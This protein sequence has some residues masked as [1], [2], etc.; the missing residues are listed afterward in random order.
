MNE[1]RDKIDIGQYRHFHVKLRWQ[2][3][4]DLDLSAFMLNKDGYIDD[5]SDL[6]FY[7]SANRNDEYDPKRY[8]SEEDWIG[9]T[10]PVSSDKSLIGAVDAEGVSDGCSIETM[11]LDLD[12][13]K[14]SICKIVFCVS[15][16]QS[17]VQEN[18]QI[19]PHYAEISLVGADDGKELSAFAF[20]DIDSGVTSIELYAFSRISDSK[21]WECGLCNI[22]H[23]AGLHSIIDKYV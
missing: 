10:I 21:E 11:T 9:K 7:N 2:G 5:E 1:A 14:P 3:D 4:V 8:E 17:S 13:V 15:V 19:L 6:V 22:A 23:R 16:F 18:R 12:G 20:D